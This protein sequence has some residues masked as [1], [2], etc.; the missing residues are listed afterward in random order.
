MLGLFLLI[1]HARIYLYTVAVFSQNCFTLNSEDNLAEPLYGMY[2][3][4][5]IMCPTVNSQN[6]QNWTVPRMVF[7]SQYVAEVM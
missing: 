5:R 4:N 1:N 7:E 3:H 2:E 6:S